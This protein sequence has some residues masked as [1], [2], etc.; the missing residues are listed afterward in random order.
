MS[1][2]YVDFALLLNSSFTQ[3]DDHYTFR[4]EKGEGGK[5][6]LVLAPN[7][8]RQTFQ[9]IEQWFSAF[10]VFVA[11]YSEKAPYDTPA[12]MKYGSVI[13]ELANWETGSQSEVL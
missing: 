4:V 10:Q 5:R 11:I 7:P 1:K 12:L 2:E 13:R 3:S 8:K 6:A 9:S